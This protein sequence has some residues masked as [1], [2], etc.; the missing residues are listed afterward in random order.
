MQ[1]AGK[2]KAALLTAIR[3]HSLCVCVIVPVQDVAVQ[4]RQIVGFSRTAGH[5]LQIKKKA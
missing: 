1:H 2:H 5:L 3:I 4:R